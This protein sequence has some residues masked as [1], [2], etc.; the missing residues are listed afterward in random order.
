MIFLSGQT[1]VRRRLMTADTVDTQ[2][3]RVVSDD[4]RGLLLW[5]PPDSLVLLPS[6][7]S[8][9]VSW[10]FDRGAFTGW[11]VSLESPSTRWAD[12]G[13]VGVESVDHGLGLAVA[14]DHTWVR[15]HG[16]DEPVRADLFRVTRL[17]E[18][19]QFP[20]DGTWCDF[21]PTNALNRRPLVA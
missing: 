21:H 11:S 17:V 6:A 3:C 15:E 8:Y 4:A 20:F 13:S 19:R 5:A 1:I 9:A 2:V 18:A 7:G 12:S 14:P 16:P 10:H